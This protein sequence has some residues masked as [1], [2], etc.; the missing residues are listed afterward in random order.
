MLL[1]FNN[2]LDQLILDFPCY[3][4]LFVL[5]LLLVLKAF[6]ILNFINYHQLIVHILRVGI[7]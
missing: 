6:L 2:I 3:L 4:L 5:T 7:G 1:L